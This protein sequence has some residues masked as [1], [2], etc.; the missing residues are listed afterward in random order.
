M[1]KI[2]YIGASDSVEIGRAIAVRDGDPIDLPDDVAKQLIE[3]GDFKKASSA[4]KSG[5]NEE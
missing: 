1:T 2:V 3:T 5:K 4:A